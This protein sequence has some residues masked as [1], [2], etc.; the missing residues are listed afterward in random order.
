MREKHV[1]FSTRT[2]CVIA[3]AVIAILMVGLF[4]CSNETPSHSN[5]NGI[6]SPAPEP[7]GANLTFTTS[8]NSIILGGVNGSYEPDPLCGIE[9]TVHN[10]LAVEVDAPC[11]LR[12]N[13]SDY[14]TR[15]VCIAG[16]GT[17]HTFGDGV[18]HLYAT[19][20]AYGVARFRISGFYAN[21]ISCGGGQGDSS[22]PRKVSLYI[23]GLL[24]SSTFCNVSTADLNATGGVTNAD[25]TKFNIDKNCANYYSRSDFDGNG[26]VNS[27]DLDIISG[28]VSGGNSTNSECE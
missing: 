1:Y 20:D 3:S 19:T 26:F 11:E 22:N 13:E 5:Q 25:V 28:I 18:Q 4:G 24:Q 9:I 6:S 7:D 2:V 8:H 10:G 27:A 15:V 16:S 21:T 14:P 12:W 23:D 17:T